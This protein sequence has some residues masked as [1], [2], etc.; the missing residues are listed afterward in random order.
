VSS[1]LLVQKPVSVITKEIVSRARRIPGLIRQ[2]V[3]PPE[4][5]PPAPPAPITS[6]EPAEP[7]AV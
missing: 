4:A 2:A 7:V 5:A 3:R 6:P 1:S